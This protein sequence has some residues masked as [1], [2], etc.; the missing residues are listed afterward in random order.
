MM[1]AEFNPSKNGLKCKDSADMEF[2]NIINSPGLKIWL[3]LVRDGVE[4]EVRQVA[5]DKKVVLSEKDL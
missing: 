1:N 5:K 2:Y 3:S 4:V